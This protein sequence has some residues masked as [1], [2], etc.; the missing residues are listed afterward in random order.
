MLASV[1]SAAVRVVESYLIRVEVNLAPELPSFVVVG[2]PEG[3]VR[4]GRERVTAAL[5]NTGHD[6]PLHRITVNLRFLKVARTI[7]NFEGAGPIGPA[8]A[9]EAIQYRTLGRTGVA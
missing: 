7:A 4:E 5:Q 1:A 9:A 3:A 8:H 6:L 2:L